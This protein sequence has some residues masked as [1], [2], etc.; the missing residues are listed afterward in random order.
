MLRFCL[1]FL[2]AGSLLAHHSVNATFDAEKP[3][4]YT[5]V[6]VTAFQMRNPHAIFTAQ[7]NGQTWEFELAGAAALQASGWRR[8]SLKV[9]DTVTVR[10]LPAKDGSARAHAER[11]I[12][13]DGHALESKDNWRLAPAMP[14]Q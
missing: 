7:V 5:S 12:W 2:L 13:A 10:A 6:T 3:T 4:D 8:D 11:I 1:P 9:G 14:K